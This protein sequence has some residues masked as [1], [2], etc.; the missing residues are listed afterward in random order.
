MKLTRLFSDVASI[1][2]RM[3]QTQSLVRGS[4]DFNPAKNVNVN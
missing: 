3:M 2:W 1:K 4:A